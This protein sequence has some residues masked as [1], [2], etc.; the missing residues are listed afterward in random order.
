[1]SNFAV[2]KKRND[3][4]ILETWNPVLTEYGVQEDPYLRNWLS[5]SCHIRAQWE[6]AGSVFESA[7]PGLFFQKPGSISAM[8]AIFPPTNSQVPFPGGVKGSPYNS[9]SGDKFPTLM[10]IAIQTAGKTVAFEFTSVINMDAPVGFM[11]YLDY[12]YAGGQLDSEFPPFLIKLPSFD[13]DLVA[14][15]TTKTFGTVNIGDTFTAY[16]AADVDQI[17]LVFVGYSRVDGTA[18]FRV[19]NLNAATVNAAFIAGGYLAD[20]GS[21][22]KWNFTTSNNIPELVS[23]LE[24]QISGFT[25]TN[26]SSTDAWS[27]NYLPELDPSTGNMNGI[28]DSM[29]REQG[30]TAF[31]RQMGLRMFT[32]FVE[33]KTDQVGISATIE[34]IQDFNRVW[35]FDVIEMLQNAATNDIA[36]NINKKLVKEHFQLAALHTKEIGKAE[37]AGLMT[38]SLAAGGGFENTMTLQRRVSTKIL[39][40]GNLILHRSR[41][42]AGEFVVTN[43][44]IAS[45]IQDSAGNQMQTAPIKV[46]AGAGNLYPAGEVYGMKIYVDP[47]LKWG[48]NK[49][50]I[51]RKGKDDEPG[52][53]FM[54]YIMAESIGT[55]SEGT[56]SPKI[57]IKSRYA[58]TQAGWHPETKY[59]LLQVDGVNKIVAGAPAV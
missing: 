26:E 54:P 46:A 40:M 25:S 10:P 6:N 48:D 47:N 4:Q 23:A 24:N 31:Y 13:V 35:N 3:T 37:G 59:L 15:N 2:F 50:L 5:E 52:I 12:V 19:T 16:N 55:V 30:E 11:P 14:S 45:A 27:G 34:Q 20:A 17:D 8:G 42:G 1:M 56:M 21:T 32:K 38:L 7:M 29:T 36:Q 53:K 22:D 9:G 41:W 18:C 33:A 58:I 51:G 49:I 28:P 39:E 44:R 43:G 57:V